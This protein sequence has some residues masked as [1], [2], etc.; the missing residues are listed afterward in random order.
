MKFG[1]RL[2]AGYMFADHPKSLYA[3]PDVR[4]LTPDCLIP[5]VCPPQP[6][7]TTSIHRL[8]HTELRNRLTTRI[9][10]SSV[11]SFGRDGEADR[12]G[13]G[14]LATW[15][16]LNSAKLPVHLE[17]VCVRLLHLHESICTYFHLLVVLHE[18]KRS[19]HS[20]LD[21]MSYNHDLNL[22][23]LSPAQ[24]EVGAR[25]FFSQNRLR[26]ILPYFFR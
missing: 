13:S 17:L 24:Q 5:R 7:D 15:L 6:L 21:T 12:P 14:C 16:P 11:P 19:P 10:L 3:A 2:S 18:V 23:K 25:L 4:M 8:A 20:V 9:I 1:W 22:S 26:S